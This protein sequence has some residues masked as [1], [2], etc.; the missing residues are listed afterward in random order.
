MTNEEFNTCVE[1]SILSKEEMFDIFRSIASNGTHKCKFSPLKRLNKDFPV[2]SEITGS[3]ETKAPH[4]F[5]LVSSVINKYYQS[6]SDIVFK[7]DNPV[8]LCG[9]G[10]FGRT[11]KTE[12]KIRIIFD[13][14]SLLGYGILYD[15]TFTIQ[16]DGT[17]K[18][19]E[20]LFEREIL[21]DSN[22][23]YNVLIL[24]NRCE[25]FSG[26]MRFSA[27]CTNAVRFNFEDQIGDEANRINSIY[28][29]NY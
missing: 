7:V 21:L 24:S 20:L 9:I 4:I 3:I 12:E 2:Q 15:K 6:Q 22:A 10:I 26:K 28:W 19:Y 5:T 27:I 25:I 29:K 8:L 13:S 18:T 11:D 1:D 16:N 17:S 14:N 23:M